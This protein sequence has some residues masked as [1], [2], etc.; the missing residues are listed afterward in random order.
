MT[1]IKL[2]EWGSRLYIFNDSRQPLRYS[3]CR[4][5]PASHVHAWLHD[6]DSTK[7]CEALVTGAITPK[8]L[9]Q[10]SRITPCLGSMAELKWDVCREL[11]KWPWGAVC[12]RG[13][14]SH[15]RVQSAL[16]TPLVRRPQA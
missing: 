1:I 12:R 8:H 13:R 9:R 14:I 7:R 16:L 11:G 4:S 3:S 2:S 5:Q 15:S 6:N 10:V